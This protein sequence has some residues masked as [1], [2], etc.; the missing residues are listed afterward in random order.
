MGASRWN[1]FMKVVFPHSAGWIFVG[2]RL[3]LPRALIAAVVGEIISSNQGL[4]YL[5][6]ESGGMFDVAGILVAVGVLA[7]LGVL[8]NS[9]VNWMEITTSKYRFI[10]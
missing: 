6:E 1:V 5:I 10:E 9:L 3:A 4:G 2:L 8:L 7:V